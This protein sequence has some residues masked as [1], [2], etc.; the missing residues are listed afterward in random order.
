[1]EEEHARHLK[2]GLQILRKERLYAKFSKCEFWMSQVAFLGH[3]VTGD[4]IK[5]DHMKIK[6]VLK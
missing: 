1:M 5:V 4:K 6:T 3:V 2:M